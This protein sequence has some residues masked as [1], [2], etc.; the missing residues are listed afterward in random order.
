MAMVTGS[1]PRPTPC[2]ARPA[3]T[4]M[5]RSDTAATTQPTS[6]TDRATKITWRCFGPSASRPITGV[7]RAPVRRA[8][9][10]SHWPV[11]KET[12]SWP[13]IVGMRGAP[14][15]FMMAT[16]AATETSVGTNAAARHERA[17]S[18]RPTSCPTGAVIPFPSS[19]VRVPS[20]PTARWV[21]L[22]RP[23][24][25]ASC[26]LLMSSINVIV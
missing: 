3:T 4:T 23:V 5:N 24:A 25:P 9:V 17:G 19:S 2:S 14:R 15:L 6:T 18:P 7:A 20:V 21:L 12:W 13:A 10:S 26:H 1:S 22:A 11:L 8:A 16:M